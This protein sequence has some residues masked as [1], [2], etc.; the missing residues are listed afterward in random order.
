MTKLEPG[1]PPPPFPAER[2]PEG[3]A[4]VVAPD[5][6]FTMIPEAERPER[7]CR[8]TLPRDPATGRRPRCPNAGV[9]FLWRPVGRRALDDPRFPWAYC[10]DHLY[11][12]W[13]EDGVVVGWRARAVEGGTPDA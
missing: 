2:L 13:V 11:G 7:R 4:W 10:A 12:R 6:D 8:W 9:A 5:G 3:H 1:R